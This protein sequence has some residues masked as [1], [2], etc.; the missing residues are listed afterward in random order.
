MNGTTFDYDPEVIYDVAIVNGTTHRGKFS[1]TDTTQPSGWASFD[2]YEP[3]ESK[4][5][6]WLHLNPAHIIS[7]S[8]WL[9]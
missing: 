6:R 4:P 1:A 5:Q 3:D 9:D 2:L 8:V 7:T